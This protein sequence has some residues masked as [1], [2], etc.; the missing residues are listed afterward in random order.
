[1][2]LYSFVVSKRFRFFIYISIFLQTDVQV[3]LKLSFCLNFILT[4]SKILKCSLLSRLYRNVLDTI[5]RRKRNSKFFSEYLCL[6]C[7]FFFKRR[8]VPFFCTS[9]ELLSCRVLEGF[10]S[11]R[12]HFRINHEIICRSLRGRPSDMF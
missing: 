4:V 5:E 1:M 2:N 7:I 6:T 12:S 8:T 10:F 9:C 11:I 3:V